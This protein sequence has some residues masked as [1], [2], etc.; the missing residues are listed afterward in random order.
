MTGNLFGEEHD[1]NSNTIVTTQPEMRRKAKIG[2]KLM[3]EVRRWQYSSP[4]Q[5]NTTNGQPMT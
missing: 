5:M 1:R 3:N 4:V 2:V